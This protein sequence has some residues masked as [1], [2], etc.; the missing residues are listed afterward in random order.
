MANR[1]TCKK[2]VHADDNMCPS[3]RGPNP[4]APTLMARIIRNPMV[5]ALIIFAAHKCLTSIGFVG[6]IVGIDE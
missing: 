1:K 4:V 3:C 5:I 2:P 6:D